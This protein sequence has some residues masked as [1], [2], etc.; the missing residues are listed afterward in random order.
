V[1]DGNDAL[2]LTT[3]RA[4]SAKK[5][6]AVAPGPVAQAITFRAFGAEVT[7]LR[8][9]L[10]S[11]LILV[12][13]LALF[14]D[15]PAQNVLQNNK[16]LPPPKSNLVA[17]HWPDLSKLE[18]DV[19][20]Q[21]LSLQNSLATVVKNT[22][23]PD[24]LLSEAYGTMGEIYHAYSL[25]A[26]AQE[27][28]LNASRLAP[29]DF[30]WVY[31]LAKLDQLEGRFDEAISRFQIA[32]RLRPEDVVV[33][34]NL[35]QIFMQ[36]NRLEEAKAS[37]KAALDADDKI[38]AAQYGLGQI[39]LASRNYTEAISYFEKALSL[40]PG[41]NRIHYSLAM[42]Y[43]GLGDMEKARQHLAQQGT[44]GV[45]VADP[46]VDGLQEL[47]KGERVHL[48]RGRL[49]LE[50]KRY[51]EAV[52]EFRKAVAAKPGSVPAHI[53]LGAALTQTGDLKGAAA[54]F[55]EILRV[56]PKNTV[57]HFNLAVLSANE[58]R[59]AQAIAHLESVLSV[60]AADL[61]ARF[62]LAQQLLK[63]GRL[64][65]ALAEFS[66]VAQADPNNEEALLEQVKLLQRSRQHKPA[67]DILE[68]SHARYPQ[69]GQ[70]TLMLGYT[71]AASPQLD[72]RNGARAL[73]L[74]QRV[75][76]TTGLLQHGAVVAMA[77]AELGRCSEAAEWVRK[78]IGK[79]E[80]ERKTELLAKLKADLQ[81]YDKKQAC[82]PGVR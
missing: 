61:T 11:C 52:T 42:A 72:L 5:L 76:Q 78:L 36:L 35:G 65:N 7:H 29:Q 68:T 70:T 10:E 1:I 73:E 19:R 51:A 40:A 23:T 55:E 81:L 47:I 45:R 3:F 79:A 46:L 67:L 53:N 75:Y 50:A 71:L 22:A 4:F 43:R 33:P 21:L 17:V 32:G 49:A 6:Q 60:D 44:V 38:P 25:I 41:A 12:M 59:P 8:K 58:N 18:P 82:R 14:A 27:C 2:L 24:A 9:H 28:Y 64:E 31:L 66:R 54:Q 62:L 74:A 37:F 77:L 15:V 20:E 63:S 48:I 13:I 39:A 56:D 16:V 57:A 80:Q 30:R 26:P 69:K 34:V